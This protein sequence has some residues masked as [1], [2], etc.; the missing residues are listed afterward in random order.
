M[1]TRG[2]HSSPQR[3]HDSG[4]RPDVGGPWSRRP[5]TIRRRTRRCPVAGDQSVGGDRNVGLESARSPSREPQASRGEHHLPGRTSSPIPASSPRARRSGAS[6]IAC[7]TATR[8]RAGRQPADAAAGGRRQPGSPLAAARRASG[9]GRRSA[10][11]RPDD[12][13]RAGGVADQGLA[14]GAQQHPAEPAVARPPT[15]LRPDSG[16]ARGRSRT[17]AGRAR[18][19]A[20]PRA[21]TPRRTRWR[22]PRHSS[23]SRRHRPRRVP[24]PVGTH[25]RWRR[26]S[27]RPDSLRAQPARRRWSPPVGPKAN[28]LLAWTSR[29]GWCRW[30]ARRRPQSAACRADVEPSTPT[31]IVARVGPFIAGL[32][33]QPCGRPSHRGLPPRA[34]SRRAGRRRSRARR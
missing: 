23:R 31:T 16:N 30:A 26:G 28:S 14:G 19:P 4:V 9:A 33:R 18:P 34:R 25:P 10:L 27:P 7:T 29:S 8:P 32:L 3:G 5:R 12:H 22:S 2:Q 13:Q 1:R 21:R 11:D 20:R 17:P 15:S 24:R 6:G